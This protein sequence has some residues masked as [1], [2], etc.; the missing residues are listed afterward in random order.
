MAAITAEAAAERVK[1]EPVDM[2]TADSNLRP[3][4]ATEGQRLVSNRRFELESQYRLFELE[5]QCWA[6][7]L[8][9]SN[10]GSPHWTNVVINNIVK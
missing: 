5:S 1:A 2:A 8:I 4:P 10:F 6:V 7:E 3:S 9:E